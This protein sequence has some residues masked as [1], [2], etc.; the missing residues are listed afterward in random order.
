MY[1]INLINQPDIST[2]PQETTKKES[3]VSKKIEELEQKQQLTSEFSEKLTPTTPKKMATTKFQKHLDMKTYLDNELEKYKKVGEQYGGVEVKNIHGQNYV[4]PREPQK[5]SEAHAE[6]RLKIAQQFSIHEPKA[7]VEAAQAWENSS[8]TPEQLHKDAESFK[9]EFIDFLKEA[10][11]NSH[12]KACMGPNNIYVLKS[13]KSLSRKVNDDVK[14]LRGKSP[15]EAVKK[16][17]SKVED[18]LRGT[19]VVDKPADIT[20]V[21]RD[22]QNACNAKGWDISLTN[23][24]QIETPGG[25]V[26]V[27][28]K[29]K[30]TNKENV[31][32][33][34]EV[35]IH[36]P[37]I[38]DGSERC[39]KESSHGIYEYRREAYGPT[40]KGSLV[41]PPAFAGHVSRLQFLS[42]MLE[43]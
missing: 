26:G 4:I 32:V 17:V 23:I 28:A 12:G 21:V 3:T 6:I 22:L 18:A 42:H 27:H 8:T 2:F 35:Q 9:D 5:I 19:I 1:P 10:A 37:Q 33:L 24:W 34:S 40:K 31:T 14:T 13:T 30:L 16:A 15:E 7:H 11:A 39:V 36:L 41:T 38:Y 25:Y 29:I 20:T 43:I